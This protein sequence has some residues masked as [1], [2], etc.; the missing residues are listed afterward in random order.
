MLLKLK[1]HLGTRQNQI[2]LYSSALPFSKAF[3]SFLVGMFPKPWLACTASFVGGGLVYVESWILLHF[4]L[5][6]GVVQRH[7]WVFLRSYCCCQ[8]CCRHILIV[9][10]AADAWCWCGV[11]ITSGPPSITVDTGRMVGIIGY[12]TTWQLLMVCCSNAA[13][14]DEW[15]TQTHNFCLIP[16]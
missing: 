10:C 4:V 7:I 12:R 15:Y 1:I 16:L 3:I 11:C 6:L 14:A 5:A 8:K 2:Y 9:T 13:T